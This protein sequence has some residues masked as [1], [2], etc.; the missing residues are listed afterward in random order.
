MINVSSRMEAF[1]IGQRVRIVAKHYLQANGFLGPVEGIVTAIDGH[2][3]YYAKGHAAISLVGDVQKR[4]FVACPSE[5]ELVEPVEPNDDKRYLQT[6]T[7]LYLE[8]YSQLA[9]EDKALYRRLI[10]MSANPLLKYKESPERSV[11]NGEGDN[12]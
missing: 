1:E 10:Y 11:I 9:E 4:K 3:P 5:C 8:T 12:R 6:L 7:T 2:A